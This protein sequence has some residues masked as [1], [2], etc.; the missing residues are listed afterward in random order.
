[1]R[2]F[3]QTNALSGPG[4]KWGE[5]SLSFGP[6]TDGG[7]RSGRCSVPLRRARA[8]SSIGAL[9][10]WIPPQAPRDL[11][12]QRLS[13]LYRILTAFSAAAGA[14]GR[15]KKRSAPAWIESTN[16]E[17]E[18]NDLRSC[19]ARPESL[20]WRSA[21]GGE[22]KCDRARPVSTLGHSATAAHYRSDWRRH[23]HPM[24]LAGNQPYRRRT[25]SG[26]SA[27]SCP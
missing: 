7:V 13:A 25:C 21:K 14:G 2:G 5:G 4:S 9:S 12:G 8:C 24:S 11:T 20:G 26:A 6:G 18:R 10:R 22:A 17:R 1:M 23:S 15:N 3:C 19:F 16:P 27:R